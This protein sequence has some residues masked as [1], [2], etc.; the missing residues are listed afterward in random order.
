[1]PAVPILGSW[2][3]GRFVAAEVLI[4]EDMLG[5]EEAIRA[6]LI[7]HEIHVTSSSG[8]TARSV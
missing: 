4:C 7:T 1:V 3:G 5:A 2:R 6:W 8:A